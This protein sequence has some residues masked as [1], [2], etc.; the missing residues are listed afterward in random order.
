LKVQRNH[1]SQRSVWKIYVFYFLEDEVK[2]AMFRKNREVYHYFRPIFFDVDLNDPA[3]ERVNYSY[4]RLPE[5]KKLPHASNEN[6]ISKNNVNNEFI[7]IPPKCPD[8]YNI[9]NYLP[10]PFNSEMYKL[11][12]ERYLL[13]LNIQKYRAIIKYLEEAKAITDPDQR[14]LSIEKI[15]KSNV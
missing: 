14:A 12:D 4:M 15:K 3:L 1:L 13:D 9:V 7:G 10:N 2:I 5:G 11:E 8:E 6:E